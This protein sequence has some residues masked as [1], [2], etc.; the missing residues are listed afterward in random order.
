MADELTVNN[1]S[2]E[3]FVGFVLGDIH[4]CVSQEHNGRKM[5][6]FPPLGKHLP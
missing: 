5:N 1:V 2:E 6:N 4:N 3:A